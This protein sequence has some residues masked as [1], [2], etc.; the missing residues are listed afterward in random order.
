[1]PPSSPLVV[2]RSWAATAGAA[3]PPPAKRLRTDPA[4]VSAPVVT[5]LADASGLIICFLTA[6]AVL[7]V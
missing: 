4:E 3:V 7:G 2:I 1:M 5:T 6:R